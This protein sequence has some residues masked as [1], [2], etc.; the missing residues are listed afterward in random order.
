[1]CHCEKCHFTLVE[2]SKKHET[3]FNFQQFIWQHEISMLFDIE[4]DKKNQS[5]RSC[6]LRVWN[7]SAKC[8]ENHKN[9]QGS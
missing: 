2:Q 9:K 7:I 6:K 3:F 4:I 5:K 8:L 1:M